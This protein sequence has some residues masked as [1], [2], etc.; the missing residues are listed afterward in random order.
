MAADA[1]RSCL[2][3]LDVM[4]VQDRSVDYYVL[5]NPGLTEAAPIYHATLPALAWVRSRTPVARTDG[6]VP[7]AVVDSALTPLTDAERGEWDHAVE[8]ARA[9]TA[10]PY[11]ELDG[12]ALKVLLEELGLA[13]DERVSYQPTNWRYLPLIF[14]GVDV[15]P[16]DVF[17][18]Y[19]CGKGRMLLEAALQPFRKVMG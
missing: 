11:Q 18:D 14:R 4:N 15:K 8:H 2:A 16:D 6:L 17:L 13:H 19:G 3:C 10:S 7:A 12:T 5:A 9:A 1:V